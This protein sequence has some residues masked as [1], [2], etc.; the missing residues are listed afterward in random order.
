MILPIL[1]LT[2]FACVTSGNVLRSNKNPYA[3]LAQLG[4]GIDVTSILPE[5]HQIRL[6][7]QLGS[8]DLTNLQGQLGNLPSSY[9]S[10]V[11][12]QQLQT[13]GLLPFSASSPLVGNQRPTE[14]LELLQ[15]NPASLGISADTL[16]HHQQPLSIQPT[17]L[18]KIPGLENLE[19][20]DL[21][22][23]SLL[24]NLR[25]QTE[26]T[27]QNMHQESYAWGRG[28]PV[29]RAHNL[30]S[31]KFQHHPAFKQPFTVKKPHH[32]EIYHYV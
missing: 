2:I 25:E 16:L 8:L 20:K 24:A 5:Q 30:D 26:V 4:S 19:N 23:D 6:P 27:G 11:G 31:H 21:D 9:T 18:V 28:L 1:F 17:T 14:I 32:F 7:S 15:I 29:F 12:L 3:Y 13:L 22:F 10:L